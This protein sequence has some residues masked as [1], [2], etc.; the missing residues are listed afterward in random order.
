METLLLLYPE[1]T[2]SLRRCF[3]FTT[4]V[5]KNGSHVSFMYVNRVEAGYD[6]SSQTIVLELRKGDDIFIQNNDA[7]AAYHCFHYNT[8]SGFLLQQ[9]DSDQIA[10][11]R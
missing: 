11:G 8:F 7:D 3:L 1:P 10:V 9:N 2:F 6:T 5:V 4:K